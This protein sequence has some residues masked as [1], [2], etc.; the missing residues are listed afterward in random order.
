[1]MILLNGG[2]A[3]AALISAAMCVIGAK[4]N[5]SQGDAEGTFWSLVA[6][7]NAVFISLMWWVPQLHSGGT[8]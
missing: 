6:L 1:M 5:D 2:M 8:F 7:G 3:F 4:R